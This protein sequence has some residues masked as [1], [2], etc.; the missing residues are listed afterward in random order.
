M[1]ARELI[2]AAFV[3]MATPA[4]AVELFRDRGAAKDGGT[5][6]YVFA[7]ALS[8]RTSLPALLRIGKNWCGLLA[9]DQREPETT[10]K[11]R[12]ANQSALRGSD[13][14]SPGEM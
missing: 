5:L 13:S 3:A 14:D 11:R 6:E 9:E 2:L 8:P 10:R 1:G 4:F 12:R 7:F